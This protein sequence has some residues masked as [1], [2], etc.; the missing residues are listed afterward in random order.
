MH[1]DAVERTGRPLHEAITFGIA[2]KFVLDVELHGIR[3]AED[4]DANRV[5]RRDVDRQDWIEPIEQA[6]A[7]TSAGSVRAAGTFSILASKVIRNDMKR[8]PLRNSSPP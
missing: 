4:V 2:V 8:S 7:P 1:A 6:Y 5:V 3:A